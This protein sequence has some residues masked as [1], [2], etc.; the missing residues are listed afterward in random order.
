MGELPGSNPNVRIHTAHDWK[1]YD[2]LA[3]K[4]KKYKDKWFGM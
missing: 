3:E 1:N 2:D 4:M